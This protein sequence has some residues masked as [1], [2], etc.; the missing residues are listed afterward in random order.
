M[1]CTPKHLTITCPSFKIYFTLKELKHQ[2]TGGQTSQR[3]GLNSGRESIDKAKYEWVL[4]M[5]S[6]KAVYRT[7]EVRLACIIGSP[8]LKTMQPREHTNYSLSIPKQSN[9]K[10]SYKDVQ[11][12][13]VDL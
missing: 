4:K 1:S 7:V 8:R 12:Q 9:E 10:K 2:S 13:Q 6:S 5:Q 11:S 3:Q